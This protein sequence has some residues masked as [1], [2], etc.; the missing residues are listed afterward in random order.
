VV[1]PRLH[2]RNSVPLQLGLEFRLTA[3][4]RVLPAVVG[5]ALARRAIRRH[6]ALE[7]FEHQLRLLPVRHRVA[8]DEA[9]VVVHEDCH[10]QP[11]V[12]SQQEGED[13]RLPELVRLRA[14]EAC[15]GPRRFRNFGRSRREQSFFVENSPH[16]RF[17]NPQPLEASQHVGDATGAHVG[18]FLLLRQHQSPPRV[19][20]ARRVASG[21]RPARLRRQRALASA[22]KRPHPLVDGLLADAEHARDFR[23]CNSFLQHLAQ[24]SKFELRRVLPHAS[25]LLST[26][27]L[28]LPSLQP[29]Q[30]G[31]GGQR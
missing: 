7:S 23:S 25:R 21:R 13:V 3:P 17:R 29:C 26:T 18:L 19:F 31:K 15:L 30:A 6:A 9:A 14:L 12:A 4:G 11:L 1:R 16:R 20:A 27:H 5:E 8:D 24:N 22:A 28:S 2:V 10:V